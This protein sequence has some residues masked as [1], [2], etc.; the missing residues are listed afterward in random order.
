LKSPQTTL[1]MNS[2]ALGVN[3]CSNVNEF[4]DAA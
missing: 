4:D 2:P 3:V 1:A